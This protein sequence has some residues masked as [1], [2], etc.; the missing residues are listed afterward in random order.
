MLFPGSPEKIHVSRL[1]LTKHVSGDLLFSEQTLNGLGISLADLRCKANAGC[2][3]A[4]YLKDD[5]EHR[6]HE[7]FKDANPDAIH[8]YTRTD[9]KKYMFI[10]PLLCLQGL[11][12]SDNACEGRDASRCYFT[13]GSERYLLYTFY[14]STKTSG[15]SLVY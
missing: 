10:A 7:R 8:L 15:K 14:V 12:L 9:G 5:L 11:H 1:G 3:F 6:M 13:A 4:R 2:D